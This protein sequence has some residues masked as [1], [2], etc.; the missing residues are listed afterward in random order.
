ME[1][2][3]KLENTDFHEMPGLI[4]KGFSSK[5]CF[6][7][8][9][10]HIE[11]NKMYR[12]WNKRKNERVTSKVGDPCEVSQ[13]PQSI[14]LYWPLARTEDMICLQYD[15]LY[16]F[17]VSSTLTWTPSAT[18]SIDLKILIIYP[19]NARKSL[20]SDFQCR[21]ADRIYCFKNLRFC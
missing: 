20:F 18:V 4:G 10:T 13:K 21:D 15:F 16:E 2:L 3:E 7:F 6:N 11:Q 14:N 1:N 5:M 9:F 19:K 17:I 12:K 8:N